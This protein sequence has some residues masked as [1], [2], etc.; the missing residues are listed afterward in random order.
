MET[1]EQTGAKF[2]DAFRCL[3]QGGAAYIF[4]EAQPA[5][6]CWDS[7]VLYLAITIPKVF[8]GLRKRKASIRQVRDH[9]RQL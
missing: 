8:R 6:G 2:N 3:P 1:A 9:A 4:K 7:Q 5:A